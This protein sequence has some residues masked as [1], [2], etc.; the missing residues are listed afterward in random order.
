L[1]YLVIGAAARS[2]AASRQKWEMPGLRWMRLPAGENY[3]AMKRHGLLFHGLDRD[4]V[5]PAERCFTESE[6]AEARI[7]SSYAQRPIPSG[8]CCR[9]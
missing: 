2:A 1:K 5:L 8:R 6:Y 9:F 7:S 4:Y 3:E